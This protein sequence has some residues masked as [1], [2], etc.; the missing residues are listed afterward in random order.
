VRNIVNNRTDLAMVQAIHRIAHE[1]GIG[2]IAEFAESEAIRSA[3]RNLN[4]DYLQGYA[5]HRPAPLSEPIL[6]LTA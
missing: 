3:L 2:T 6:L 4:I 5:V 1:M